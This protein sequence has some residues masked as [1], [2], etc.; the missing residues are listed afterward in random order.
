MTKTISEIASLP[1]GSLIKVCDLVHCPYNRASGCDRYAVSGHCHLAYSQ[2][3]QVRDGI[4]PMASQYWL[5]A[6]HDF[7]LPETQRMQDKF[8]AQPDEQRRIQR[9]AELS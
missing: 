3:G 7:D 6:T 4:H 2:P 8:L 9:Q 1:A 5:Y